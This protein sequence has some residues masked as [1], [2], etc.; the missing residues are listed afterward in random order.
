MSPRGL[1]VTGTDTGVGKTAVTCALARALRRRGVDVGVMKPLESGCARSPDGTLL[2][3]DA[4]ALVAAAEVDDPLDAV[5]PERFEA[6]LAPALA[7][8]REG[9][10]PDLAR[11]EATFAELARRHDLVL[12]EGAGGLLVPAAGDLTMAD[13]AGRLGLPLLV[14]ARAALGTLNHSL[15]TLEAAR[16]RDL[17]VRAV[18]MNDAA[19]AAG[20]DPSVADNPAV[21]ARLGEVEVVGPLPQTVG[22]DPDRLADGLDALAAS[23]GR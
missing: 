19:G 22:A 12:V 3:A 21:L 7:A 2:P 11:I 17:P 9:R 5:C 6:P 23:L 8:A 18:V 14:V 15:L 13:L 20:E 16:R 10:A 4:L 1:F